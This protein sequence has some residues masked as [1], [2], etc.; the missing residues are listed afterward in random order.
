MQPGTT[1]LPGSSSNQ[2]ITDDKI[3]KVAAE[4]RDVT[5]GQSGPSKSQ[6]IINAI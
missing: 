1:I 2:A 6:N 5:F 3:S 4:I